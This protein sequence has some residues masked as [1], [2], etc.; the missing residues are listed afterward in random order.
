[1]P[2]VRLGRSWSSGVAG[3]RGEGRAVR[4]W[5]RAFTTWGDL[6]A[7]GGGG[8]W[9]DFQTYVVSFSPHSA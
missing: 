8:V 5:E 6:S 2:G 7:D 9:R 4:A 3:L 1:V